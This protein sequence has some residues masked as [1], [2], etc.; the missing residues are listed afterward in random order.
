M[1]ELSFCRDAMTSHLERR[2][3][4]QRRSVRDW[5]SA[6]GRP[7]I[8]IAFH[9]LHAVHLALVHVHLA[10]IHGPH[11]AMVHPRP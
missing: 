7:S 5:G 9:A 1:K 6:G 11:L 4:G 3:H 10:V 8:H 2:L